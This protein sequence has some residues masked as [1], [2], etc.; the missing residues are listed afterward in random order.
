VSLARRAGAIETSLSPTQ[1]VLRWLTEAHAYGS[2]EAYVES[3]LAEDHPVAPV[4]HARDA[5]RSVR[6]AM[7]GK[8]PKLVD[9]A[10]RAAMRETVFRLE[11]VMRINVIAHELVDRATPIDAALAAH[12]ALVAREAVGAAAGAQRLSRVVDMVA[13]RQGELQAA[14]DTRSLVAERY[15][16]GHDALFPAVAAAWRS[17]PG[18]QSRSLIWGAS[19]P[20]WTTFR[21]PLGRTQ[22]TPPSVWPNLRQT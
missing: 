20:T 10:V 11:L 18:A 9:P 17:K 5:A 19:W 12:L 16:D 2:P 4:D 14:A 7:R 13:A 1:R 3:L 22:E 6:T 15:L 21:R 8:R